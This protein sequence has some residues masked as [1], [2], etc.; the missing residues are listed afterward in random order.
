MAI[1]TVGQLRGRVWA[2]SGFGVTCKPATYE[3]LGIGGITD[4]HVFYIQNYFAIER[5]ITIKKKV[6]SV[7]HTAYEVECSPT[8]LKV[9]F[10]NAAGEGN[11]KGFIFGPHPYKIAQMKEGPNA[12]LLAEL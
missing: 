8:R 2:L 7:I 11:A 1:P 6:E 12:A 10:L 4:T 5:D 3:L 9:N